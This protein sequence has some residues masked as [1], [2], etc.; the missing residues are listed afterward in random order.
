MYYL[1]IFIVEEI[2]LYAMFSTIFWCVHLK[3]MCIATKF[4][5]DWSLFQSY[6]PTYVYRN[7]WP[8]AVY[9]CSTR[10]TLFTKV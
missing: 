5:L 1:R 6:M 10:T 9:C 4:C 3:T 2:I 7:V 8:E